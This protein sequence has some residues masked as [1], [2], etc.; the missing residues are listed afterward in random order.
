MISGLGP[1][2]APGLPEAIIFFSGNGMLWF[3]NKKH[4]NPRARA[5]EISRPAHPKVG[6][7]EHRVGLYT[8]NDPEWERN[9]PKKKIWTWG[10][11]AYPISG[12]PYFFFLNGMVLAY[13][14]KIKIKDFPRA[15]APDSKTEPTPTH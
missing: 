3:Q 7:V 6:I 12:N 10:P 8:R 13:A 2:R 9:M 15:R 5:P 11:R 14:R 4:K 1:A